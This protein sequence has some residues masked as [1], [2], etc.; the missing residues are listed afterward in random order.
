MS[1]TFQN[2]VSIRHGLSQNSRAAMADAT[3]YQAER[4]YEEEV[5]MFAPNVSR[6][7]IECWQDGNPGL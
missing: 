1:W 6:N 5:K 3:V 7:M 4:L 2:S